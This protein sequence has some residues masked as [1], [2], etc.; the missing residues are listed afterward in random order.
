VGKIILVA[1]NDFPAPAPK[2]TA[3]HFDKLIPL[4][5]TAKTRRAT[6]LKAW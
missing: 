2:P 6:A 3:P 5:A 4:A 1:S